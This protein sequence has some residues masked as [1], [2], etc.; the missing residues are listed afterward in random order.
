MLY[1]SCILKPRILDEYRISVMS[2]HTL[3]NGI[4]PD[5]RIT[6]ASYDI[7]IKE[8]APSGKLI[9]DY[10]K[11]GLSW[12]EFEEKYLREI[13]NKSNLVR[14]IAAVSLCTNISLVCIEESEELCHRRLLAEKCKKYEPKLFVCHV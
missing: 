6:P 9:G 10:Y 5:L 8:L 14:R 11:R 4:T 3:N 2:R 1:T 7:W 13:E 12:K